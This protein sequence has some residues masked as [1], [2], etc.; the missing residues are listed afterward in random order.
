MGKKEIE[1][2]YENRTLSLNNCEIF[3]FDLLSHKIILMDSI[4]FKSDTATHRK[5]IL[6]FRANIVFYFYYNFYYS[7]I[8][9]FFLIKILEIR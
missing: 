1:K 2:E 4:Q 3:Y 6:H 8:F 7:L 9:K 5:Y